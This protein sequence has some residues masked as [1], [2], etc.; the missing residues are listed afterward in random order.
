MGQITVPRFLKV[1]L[2]FLLNYFKNLPIGKKVK[3]N[4]FCYLIADWFIYFHAR[5]HT[6][7]VHA[8]T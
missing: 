6:F 5:I 1:V 2:L 3:G 7:A 4:R 8:T